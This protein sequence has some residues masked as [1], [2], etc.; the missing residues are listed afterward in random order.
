[1][2]LLAYCARAR[3]VADAAIDELP[4]GAAGTWWSGDAVSLRWVLVHVVEET[5]G[6]AGPLGIL[7]E[8]IDGQTGDSSRG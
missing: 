8:L 5:A 3:A 1:V 6:Q 7:Q 2:D 4:L